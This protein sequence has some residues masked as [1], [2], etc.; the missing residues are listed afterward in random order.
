MKKEIK[1]CDKCG[2]KL[3]AFNS[4]IS[5]PAECHNPEDPY[6]GFYKDII[7]Y[8]CKCWQVPQKSQ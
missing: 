2:R 6:D 7:F 3:K 1:Y 8:F 4:G 5:V